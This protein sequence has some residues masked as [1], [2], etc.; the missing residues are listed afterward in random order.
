MLHNK[1]NHY[2]FLLRVGIMP[3]PNLM[4]KLLGGYATP[5]TQHHHFGYV[6]QNCYKSILCDVEKWG[7][8]VY[9]LEQLVQYQPK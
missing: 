1:N 3:L 8:R 2:H 4:R 5:Y 7:R 9:L 6:F